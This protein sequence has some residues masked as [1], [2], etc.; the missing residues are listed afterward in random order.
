LWCPP[1]AWRFPLQGWRWDLA[2]DSLHQRQDRRGRPC[3]RSARHPHHVRRHLAGPAQAVGHLRARTRRRHLQDHG[4]RPHLAATEERDTVY[5]F[6]SKGFYKST[7]AGQ[8]WEQIRTPHGDYHG[9]WID[10]RN[11]QRMVNANDGGATVTFD[12]GRSWTPEDNQATA[13]FY[14]VRTDND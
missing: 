5:T 9:L 8:H 6:S 12:G 11:N 10:P 14:T 7:D 13:Q 3:G 2:E 4:R 1:G